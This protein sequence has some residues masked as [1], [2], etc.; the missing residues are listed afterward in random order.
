MAIDDIIKDILKHPTHIRESYI[1]NNYVYFHNLVLKFNVDNKLPANITFKEKLWYFINDVKIEKTCLICNSKVKFNKKFTDGYKNYCSSKCTQQNPETK[2]K[3]KNTTIH[4]YGVDNIAKLDS[5][6]DKTA[7]TNIDKYGHKSS[8]QNIE[9][10]NKWKRNVK[11][12]YGVDHVFQLDEVKKKSIETNLKKYG[13]EYFVQSDEYKEKLIEIGHAEN[14][15]LIYNDKTIKTNMS[16]YGVEHYTQSIEYKSIMSDS[17]MKLYLKEKI[18]KNRKSNFNFDGYELLKSTNGSNLH[19]KSL[20]CGHVFEILYDCFVDR[21]N[22]GHNCCL[23]CLPLHS[24]SQSV[25]ELDIRKFLNTLNVKYIP[26]YNKFGIEMDIYLP[27][28]NLAIEMNGVYWHSELKKHK[29]FHLQKTKICN[30][31]NIHLIHVWEDDW[32]YK[33]NIIKSIIKNKLGKISNRIYS[34]KCH[35]KEVN[36]KEAIEFLN[37]NHIQGYSNSKIKL[38]LY[39]NDILVSIMTFGDRYINGNRETELIRFCNLLNTSVVG[40]ASKL[41]KYY[42]SNYEFESIKS[43]ADVS[44]FDGGLYKKLGFDYTHR[45]E[46]NYYWVVNGIRKHRFNYNKKKLIKE[47]FDSMKTEVEIMHERGYYRIWGCGQDKYIYKK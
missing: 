18:F 3:R 27:D 20:S 14:M 45:T 32:K 42:I 16:K 5:I 44:M 39:H 36:S 34:R 43:Y 19:L 11:K 21:Y 28:S 38:G 8:F 10:R 31:N 46:P 2:L 40:S 4:K 37:I 30:D 13:T 1:L 29:R 41:F 24:I 9:V 22:N 26:N 47:G 35:I 6:K 23:T 7:E 17:N 25:L 12:K 33:Q 15:K